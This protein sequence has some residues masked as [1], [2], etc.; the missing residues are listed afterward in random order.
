MKTVPITA[1][2]I[3]R[4]NCNNLITDDGKCPLCQHPTERS[5]HADDKEGYCQECADGPFPANELHVITWNED[6]YLQF[7]DGD[8]STVCLK[9]YAKRQREAL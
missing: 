1:A 9:C 3:C 4:K 7:E 5:E 8:L 2:R 6:P